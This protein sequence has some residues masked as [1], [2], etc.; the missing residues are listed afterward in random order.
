MMSYGFRGDTIRSL[1]NEAKQ[2]QNV[3][4][5]SATPIERQFWFPEMQGLQELTIKWPNAKNVQVNKV[6]TVKIKKELDSRLAKFQPYTVP[7]I[8]KVLGEI[9][10]DV[11]LEKKPV[12]T[13]LNR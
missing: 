6:K 9:Y 1:L 10:E 11:N 4:Y 13:D 12:A 7:E 2:F 5:I 3:T 8:K